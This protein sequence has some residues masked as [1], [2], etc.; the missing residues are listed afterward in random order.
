MLQSEDK[1]IVLAAS[2]MCIAGL[3]YSRLALDL[4][5]SEKGQPLAK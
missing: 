1:K 5:G 2:I 3:Y 4:H